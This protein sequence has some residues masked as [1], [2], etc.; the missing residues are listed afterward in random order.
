MNRRTVIVDGPLAYR[1]RRIAAARGGETGLQIFTLPL[2]AARLAGGFVRP[3]QTSDLD[4][5][6]RTALEKGG[7]VEIERIRHL[8]GMTR[9]IARTL[10]KLWQADFSLAECVETS[11]RLADLLEVEQR[12]RAN[13]P[14]GTLTPRDLRDAAIRRIAHA[15]AVLGSVEFDGRSNIAPVW[16]PFVEALDHRLPV[17][18]RNAAAPISDRFA[19]ALIDGQHPVASAAVIVS[20]A[21][22]RSEVVEALRWMREIIASRRAKPEEIAICAPATT[23]WDDHFFVLAADANLPLHFSHGVP[24]LAS[25]AGQACAALADVLLKGISQD[26]IRRLFGHSLGRSPALRDLPGNWWLGLQPGAALFELDQWRRSL[27]EASCRRTDGIDV[28]A[29]LLPVLELLAK[30]IDSAEQAASMLLGT[31]ARS[32]WTEALRRAPAKALDLSLQDLRQPDGRDPGACAVWCPASHLAAAPRAW[33]RLLGL[34]ARSWP[35]PTSEDPL[36]PSH[37]LPRDLLDPDPITDQDRRSFQQITASAAGGCVLSQSRRNAQGGLQSA[38]PLTPHNFP[39]RV[40]KRVR[41]PHHAFSEADRSLARLDE[42]MVEP[43][44]AAAMACWRNWRKPA[45]TSHDGWTRADHPIVARAIE[46]VQSATSLRLMLRDPLA[47]VWRYALGWRQVLEDDQPL[48]LDA[49]A[50]GEL[51]HQLLKKTV[52]GLEPHPGYAQATR[53]EIEA[54]LVAAKSD[55]SAQWPLERSVPPLMLWQHT[56]DEAGRLALKALTFDESFKRGTRSWTEVSFGRAGSAEVTAHDLPWQ[57]TAQVVIVG[58]HVRI[59]GD[60]DRLDLTADGNAVRV[61]D[62]KTGPEPKRAD[63]IVLD[64]GRELQR[65]IYALAARQLLPGN[66]KVVARLLYLGDDRPKSYEL[67]DVDQAITDVAEHVTAASVLLRRGAILPGLDAREEWSD[68]RLLLPASR[69]IYF[70][71]KQAALGRALGGYARVWKSR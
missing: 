45:I 54:S 25:H 65:V 29:T 49:R 13:L 19:S 53:G 26:R 31:G 37:V 28:R 16:K 70:R 38:S 64:G 52:D 5:A 46:Q 3:A 4:S 51:V 17:L 21:N 39:V 40:L 57:P 35:R 9:A 6:I 7:F 42:T 30:G 32:L 69:P 55:V 18:W 27:D 61:S 33:V 23:D 60:I 67:P 24:A 66:P 62:Y 10:T 47:F 71:T 14:D 1:M 50:Y 63:Q 12:V 34:T 44:A 41:I 56:L 15:A 48:T 20:C 36:L 58:T 22:P 11:A 8:P 59:Q 2:L 43:S 68:F